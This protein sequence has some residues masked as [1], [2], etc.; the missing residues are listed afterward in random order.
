MTTFLTIF[1]SGFGVGLLGSLHCVGMCGPLA[2]TLPINNFNGGV[3][4]L[5]VLA[6]NIGRSVTYA[7]F[8][9]GFGL[10]GNGFVFFGWQQSLSILSGL[11]ILSFVLFNYTGLA[12]TTFVQAISSFA[13]KN[14]HKYLIVQTKT[15]SLF[16]IGMLNGL[17]PCGLVYIALAT[18][19]ATGN[20][21]GGALIMFAFGLGTIPA[22]AA[23]M[24][25]KKY[26]SFGFRAKI[27]MLTPYIITMVAMLL[28]I[29]GLNLGIPYLSPKLE[30]NK[31]CVIRC[32]N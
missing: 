31:A 20:A 21:I 17:L 8:G 19:L 29:R 26:I 32:C 11:L 12:Q 13:K 9:L 27:K 24:A 10:L 7:L 3:H 22:M 28:I 2:M 14:I 23:L 18:A 1:F 5:K 4:W 25:F 16:L 30:A 6:Y 15:G